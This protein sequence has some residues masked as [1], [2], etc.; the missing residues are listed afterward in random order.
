M[1]GR[2]WAGCNGDLPEG[3]GSYLSNVCNMSVGRKATVVAVVV[4]R[5]TGHVCECPGVE[6]QTEIRQQERV[7]LWVCGAVVG[8]LWGVGGK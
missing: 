3:A 4:V 1:E 5:G 8:A 6:V 2:G 7:Y